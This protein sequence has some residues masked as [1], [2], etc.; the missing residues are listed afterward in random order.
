MKNLSEVILYKSPDILI[1]QEVENIDVLEQLQKKYLLSSGY[2]HARLVEGK[3]KRGIDVA[4]SFKV[5]SSRKSHVSPGTSF[6]SRVAI[7]KRYLT[8]RF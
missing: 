5:C 7:Y 2:N 8:G 1:L 3:D 4:S 6:K